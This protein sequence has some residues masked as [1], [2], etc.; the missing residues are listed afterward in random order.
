M[1]KYLILS[2]LLLCMASASAQDCNLELM[3][4]VKKSKAYLF[5]E[6]TAA[7]KSGAVKAAYDQLEG[8]IEAWVVEHAKKKVKSI[9]ATDVH[10][11]VDTLYLKRVNMVLAFVY[12]KKSNLVPVYAKE[13][14]DIDDPDLDGDISVTMTSPTKEFINIDTIGTDVAQAETQP[15]AAEKQPETTAEEDDALTKIKSVKTFFELEKVMVPLK[16]KGLIADYGKFATLEDPTQAYLI[17]YDPAGNIRAVLDKETDDETRM[18]LKTQKQ[19]SVKNYRG[20]G[21]IWFT[22]AKS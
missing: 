12:V 17:V 3:N 6:M 19:D 14:I 4:N 20:C 22:L 8:K 16:E 1:K 15:S 13:G 5:G 10:N 21:A 2:L 9:V 7:D 18:N 11:L